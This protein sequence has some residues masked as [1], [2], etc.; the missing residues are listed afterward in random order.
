MKIKL[1]HNPRCS[2]SRAA[3]AL[4]EAR[5][6]DFE[7]ID[8]LARPLARPELE[9]LL[10]KLGQPASALVRTGEPEFRQSGLGPDADANQLLDLL[11][12]EPR[13]LQR[14]IVETATRACIARPPERLLDLL[15]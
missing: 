4:L 1:Y 11:A 10:A 14:P 15:V 3:L 2:K 12:A 7:P 5:N 8:Y 6:V 9:R 13:L